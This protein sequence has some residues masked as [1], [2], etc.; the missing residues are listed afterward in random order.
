MA[1]ASL[2]R[3]SALGLLSRGSGSC[4]H[5]LRDRGMGCGSDQP[6][7]YAP[8]YVDEVLATSTYRIH[9]QPM[10]LNPWA[11]NA[12]FVVEAVRDLRFAGVIDDCTLTLVL[13]QS[14]DNVDY[15]RE[16]LEALGL[17]HTRD[18]SDDWKGLIVY[19]PLSSECALTVGLRDE[20]TLL[21]DKAQWWVVPVSWDELVDMQF[22]PHS[23]IS[24]RVMLPVACGHKC[25]FF[26]LVGYRGS[27]YSPIS[28]D[29]DSQA[30]VGWY[31]KMLRPMRTAPDLCYDC[32]ILSTFLMG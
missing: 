8:R 18:S 17:R 1:H 29:P 5:G 10:S 21:L 30:R 2:T 9:R 24:S 32:R 14:F 28:W 12:Y 31:N 23:V 19:R 15:H 26:C 27:G 13:G 4:N 20:E 16:S 7:R 11:C 6:M 22:L 3:K 25:E